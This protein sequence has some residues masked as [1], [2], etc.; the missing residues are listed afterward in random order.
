MPI[1]Y[2]QCFFSGGNQ[3]YIVPAPFSSRGKALSMTVDHA[4]WDHWWRKR[5]AE[6]AH[7]PRHHYPGGVPLWLPP[8]AGH[9]NPRRCTT[10]PGHTPRPCRWCA[11][12]TM[13]PGTCAATPRLLSTPSA[14]ALSCA[15]G[16]D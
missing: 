1:I 13:P 15:T 11:T 7:C 9:H 5:V 16:W 6:G 12:H 10:P 4:C 8:C 14:R 2:G 3:G